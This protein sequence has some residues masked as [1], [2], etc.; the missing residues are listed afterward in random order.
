M[1]RCIL[2]SLFVC[3]VLSLASWG[4]L[5][6]EVRIEL[7]GTGGFSAPNVLRSHR[8][9]AASG[10]TIGIVVCEAA[11]GAVCFDLSGNRMWE[12]PMESR[13]TAAPAVADVDGDGAE[14]VVVA[15]S[16]GNLVALTGQ[17]KPLWSARL[18]G[19]VI[20]D[21]CPAVAD[22][23]NDGNPEV[24]VGD[25]S[26]AVSCFDNSGKRCWR[27]TGDGSQ[28][29]PV[30]VADLYD[31]PG[32]E[33]V[34]TSHDQHIYALTAQG[35]WLWDVYTP[36][37]LF[38]NST[39]ILADVDADGVPELY[40]GGGLHHFYCIDLAR[41]EI[42]LA[43]NVY[44]H[45]NGA[46]AAADLEGDGADEVIFGNKSG[47]VWCY[48]N[49]GFKWTREFRKSN[50]YAAPMMLDLD[51][52]P[53][54]EILFYSSQGD[55]QVLD[56]DGLLLFSA[57]TSCR[58]LAT[59]LAGD[60]DGDGQLE[61]VAT[62]LGGYQGNGVLQVFDF[63]VPYP[64][65][66]RWTTFAGDRAHTGRPAGAAA[67]PPLPTPKTTAGSAGATAALDGPMAVFS[68]PNT[69]R[70]NVAN[71]G[72]RRLALIGEWAYP[73]GFMRRF[74]RHVHSAKERA[75]VA[76][77][78]E[79]P[80]EYAWA[81]RLV[82]A[83]TLALY[84][85]HRETIAFTGFDSDVQ[86]LHAS[87]FKEIEETLD[88]WRATNPIR[89]AHF[90]QELISMRGA[91]TEL[92]Q[93]KRAGRVE[94]AASL[95]AAAERLRALAKAGRVLAPRGSFFAWAFNPWAY[96]D[97]RDTLP[98]PDN[99]TEQI[100]AAV[101]VGEYESLALNVTNLS[102]TALE[103]RVDAG[104][105]EGTATFPAEEHL[106]FRRAVAVPTIRR[107]RVADA[108]VGL[109]E[110][111]LLSVPSLETQQ[112]WITL[113]A[114]GLAPG[115]YAAQIMLSG[116]EADPTEV[117][118]PMAIHVHA[119]RLPRPRPLRFC[120]WAYDGGTLGTDK[121]HVLRDL[122]DHGITVFFGRAPTAT[123]DADGAITEGPDFTAHDETVKRFS[124][125]G[126]IL[127]A[128]PQ[129]GLTGQ[130]FLSDPWRKAFVT[131]MRAWAA[132]IKS[133]GIGYDGWALYPYDEPS[134]PFTDTTLNLVE[135]A[136]LV[137]EADPN[138]LIYTDP[139]SGTT[140]KTVE[141][142]TGLID[143]WCPSSEL[144]ERLGPELIPVAKRVGKHVWFYDAAGR[145]KTLSCLG[146]Y[147]WR[148]WYAWNLGL[149]G[150]G[151]WCYSHDADVAWQGPNPHNDFFGSVYAGPGGAVVSS[152]RWEAAREGVE[153]FEYLCLLRT[154]IQAAEERGVSGAAIAQANKLLEQVPG[155]IEGALHEAGRRL[156]LTPDSVPLY[157]EI[158]RRLEEARG[159]V[160][161]ACLA[162]AG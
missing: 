95:R 14:D 78:I 86:Y 42:V 159:D 73:D 38:P 143:I 145:A 4:D 74:V 45:I 60:L 17:G 2:C 22:L 130:P 66:G 81:G 135:V 152:K 64:D 76:F 97:A 117:A 67:Y 75:A 13:V 87:V 5:E 29:G 124:P 6:Y 153:D 109:D 142:F 32:K 12:Y 161:A 80:G 89:A 160:I 114:N 131:Y 77:L 108:L 44:L 70:F 107:E 147:R 49:G 21:S 54:L 104:D 122:V 79:D 100:T 119:L 157:D 40:I 72:Q 154:A 138:I 59:P 128:S 136:G 110:G 92:A 8:V 129:G 123:C 121:P 57:S 11:V 82:D 36:D 85:E 113:D 84:E 90:T 10:K 53:A 96:F 148:F 105:L 137:R 134:T 155:E 146:I 111:G 106:A 126:I 88:Q 23:D 98:T 151:W 52:D 7:T 3:C 39:P 120:T 34:V 65:A 115:D 27:F 43:E 30:L 132:H 62:S 140:M 48:G 35:Q 25:L 61:M 63:N 69:L 68:G 41:H 26:G 101:C 46:I 133:V 18:P 94:L 118:I 156:P 28:M 9:E 112:L 58:P 150:V 141:M 56:A 24:L 139:T 55:L 47:G 125:H 116:L 103:V 51:Q 31:A 1:F 99:A 16:T 83:D 19:G 144:L 93:A 127:F 71:P 102:G 91:L 50:M 158:A 20:E 162:L 15:D 149:T 33:V 37:D